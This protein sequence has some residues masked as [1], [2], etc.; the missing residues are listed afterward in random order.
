MTIKI[1]LFIIS[2]SLY[3][4]V[5]TFF[6]T[7]KTMHKIHENKGQYSFISHIF[8]IFYS[9]II[10]SGT[11][12]LLKFLSLSERSILRLKS[13]INYNM[14]KIYEIFLKKCIKI[15][16][17]LFFV[18]SNLLL[19]FFLYYI[20]CFCGIFQNTQ[21]ILFKDTLI[22]FALSMIYPIGLNLLPGLLRFFSLKA[23]KKNRKILYEISKLISFI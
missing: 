21:I 6:Y 9:T 10:S 11:Q 5:N 1:Y 17:V 13:Q 18:L 2:V 20:S 15:K 7:D 22:S 4:V 3:L 23:K 14:A 16:F 8:Q 12:F 19:L